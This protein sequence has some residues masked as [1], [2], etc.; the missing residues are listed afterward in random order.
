M[1]IIPKYK[2]A[3]PYEEITR[4]NLEKY[5]SVDLEPDVKALIVC[6]WI[7]GLRIS[8]ALMLRPYDFRDIDEGLQVNTITLKRGKKERRVLWCDNGTPHLQILK[9]YVF[10]LDQ[11]T[12]LFPMRR[13]TYWS[14]FKKLDLSLCTHRFRHHRATQLALQRATVFELQNW[15]GHADVR[16]S[17]RYIHASGIIA[18][19]LGKRIKIV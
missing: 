13:E 4:E 3:K 15:L 9:S 11:M 16:Q 19:D 18:R 10:S 14:K 1:R 2:T 6:L 7:Y 12:K 5:L 8:E 17:T